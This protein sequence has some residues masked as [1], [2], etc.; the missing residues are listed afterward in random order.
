MKRHSKHSRKFRAGGIR[1]STVNHR[2]DSGRR[3]RGFTARVDAGIFAR[4]QENRLRT[5]AH[6]RMENNRL[7]RRTRNT[8]HHHRRTNT[9][10]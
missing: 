6:R 2:D 9:R 4:E 5:L 3:L 8:P 7:T 1:H 10:H